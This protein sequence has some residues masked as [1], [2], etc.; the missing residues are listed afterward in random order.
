MGKTYLEIRE[1]LRKNDI[2]CSIALDIV[3]CVEASVNAS[4]HKVSD[5]EYEIICNYV[6]GIWDDVDKTYTQL[7][8]DIVVD[9]IW[10][11]FE[12]YTCQN[13]ELTFEEMKNHD[14]CEEVT[15]AYLD[16]YYD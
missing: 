9:C 3:S 4:G 13:I 12:F 10:H 6:R 16:K 8:A 15:Q 11:C 14:K 1:L 7:I 5:E 2:S